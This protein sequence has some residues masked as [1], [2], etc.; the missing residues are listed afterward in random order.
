MTRCGLLDGCV[1]FAETL[2]RAA[3]SRFGRALSYRAG[4]DNAKADEV[5]R[6]GR[7]VLESACQADGECDKLLDCY[8]DHTFDEPTE[9]RIEELE[10]WLCRTEQREPCSQA[11][12][13]AMRWIV[14]ALVACASPPRAPAPTTPKAVVIVSA[15]TE[16][17]VVKAVYPNARMDTT[18]WGETFEL[19][20]HT[21]LMHGGWGKVAAAGSAQYAID[22]WHPHYV[23]NL[24]TAGGFAGAIEKHA[25][26]LVER[27]II[28]DI[29]EAMGDSAEA[30]R[31]YSTTLDLAWLREPYPSAVKRTLLVSGDRD[32]IPADLGELASKYGAVAGDWESGA[33]AYTCARNHQRVLIL[34]GIT[35]LV[36][37]AGDETYGNMDAFASGADVVMRRLLAELPRWLAVMP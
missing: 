8:L 1:A 10:R 31:D 37:T 28:Y 12:L 22:R 36:S 7:D 30:I 11:I 15:N 20:D 13:R 5:L 9:G 14:L 33:I 4:G 25:V 24:G 17:K 29:K 6:V 2:L 35:D 27:T 21:I 26:I 16:W 32:L 18:P 19:P 3:A 34:R 23:V